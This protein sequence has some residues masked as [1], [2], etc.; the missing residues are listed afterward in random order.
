VTD[1]LFEYRQ[2]NQ[3][4]VGRLLSPIMIAPRAGLSAL[5]SENTFQL[6]VFAG[7]AA[8]QT[9]PVSTL[10][11]V[12]GI[13]APYNSMSCNLGGF[14]EIYE[15]GC[16]SDFLKSDEDALVLGFHNPEM[17]L[18]RRSA[19]TAN[20]YD[21]VDGLHFHVEELPNTTYANDLK[22][23]MSRGDIDAS[24]A[25]FYINQAR[26]EQRGNSR[27]RIVEKATLVE[28][29]IVSLGAYGAATAE[30]SQNQLAAAAAARLTRF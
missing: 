20:F 14:Y 6:R 24:S 5:T 18:G 19:G 16:F 29:S 9:K 15:P 3:F 2:R 11:G 22:V 23:A 30:I 27:V 10:G 4:G 7:G 21:A 17:V 28:S 25:G 8:L 13:V 1:S 26:W 12:H